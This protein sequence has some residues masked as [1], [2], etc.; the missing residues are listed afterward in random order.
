M[1]WEARFV[2]FE[3][4][5]RVDVVGERRLLRKVLVAMHLVLSGPHPFINPALAVLCDTICLYSMNILLFRIAARYAA[6]GHPEVH[7]NFG[8]LANVA[9]RLLFTYVLCAQPHAN[10]LRILVSALMGAGITVDEC[11]ILVAALSAPINAVCTIGAAVPLEDVVDELGARLRTSA[12]WSLAGS[13]SAAVRACIAHATSLDFGRA[14]RL[15]VKDAPSPI[16]RSVDSMSDDELLNSVVHK[17]VQVGRRLCSL[18]IGFSLQCP[19][20]LL[21]RYTYLQCDKSAVPLNPVSGLL[22]LGHRMLSVDGSVGPNSDTDAVLRVVL[23]S[24]HCVPMTC[25]A[26]LMSIVSGWSA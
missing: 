7:Q 3:Q 25:S 23:S 18:L 21:E 5:I 6:G 12:S 13:I 15:G 2:E 19:L 20:M 14:D 16:R 4:P 22:A 8:G 9:A 10:G 1:P 17:V 24:R 11:E 26:V